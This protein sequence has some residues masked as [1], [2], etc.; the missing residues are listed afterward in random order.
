[1]G[2]RRKKQVTKAA[3]P[4]HWLPA[5]GFLLSIWFLKPSDADRHKL[6]AT[7]ASS[8]R[9]ARLLANIAGRAGLIVPGILLFSLVCSEIIVQRIPS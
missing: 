6:S 5:T 8:N 1:M 2:G 3:N 4:P 7:R 9:L